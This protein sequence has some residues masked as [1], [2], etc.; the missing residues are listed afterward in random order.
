[1]YGPAWYSSLTRLDQERSKC[2]S[3]TTDARARVQAHVY[4]PGLVRCGLVLPDNVCFHIQRDLFIRASE[5][6]VNGLL[7]TAAHHTKQVK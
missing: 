6:A 3:R 4:S 7:S 2:C 1:M 5:R